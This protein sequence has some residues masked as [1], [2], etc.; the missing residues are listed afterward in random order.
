M[1]LGTDTIGSAHMYT[2]THTHTHTHVCAH[3]ETYIL[4]KQYTTVLNTKGLSKFIILAV[5]E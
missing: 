4:T 1:L 3:P 5:G 2:H